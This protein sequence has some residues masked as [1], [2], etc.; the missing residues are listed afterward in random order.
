MSSLGETL[1]NLRDERGL[2]QRKLAKALN[3]SSSSVS[4]F[5]TN[6]RIPTTA[7]LISYADFFNVTTD[8]LL[9]RTRDKL[10]PQIL[11]ELFIDGVTYGALLKSMKVLTPNQRIALQQVIND[12]RIS[13]EVRESANRME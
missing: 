13:A 7:N 1:V 9:G 12:M 8:Y 6:A 10:N 3:I 5:E 11:D 4:A 2:T